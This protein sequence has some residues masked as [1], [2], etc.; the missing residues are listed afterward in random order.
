MALNVIFL[1]LINGERSLL[2]TLSPRELVSNLS[3]TSVLV[4]VL[5][6]STT[7][8]VEN[9]GNAPPS[10]R[11]TDAW[12]PAP[13]QIVSQEFHSIGEKPV[14]GSKFSVLDSLETVSAKSPSWLIILASNLTASTQ[15]SDEGVSSIVPSQK[16]IKN[17]VTLSDLVPNGCFNHSVSP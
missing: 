14:C 9:L 4:P 17:G 5:L 3:E 12:I 7:L 2:T 6:L 1:D 15:V 8:D 13:V 11:L 16:L 10:W